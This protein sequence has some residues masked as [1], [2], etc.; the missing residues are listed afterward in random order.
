M[1][2]FEQINKALTGIKPLAALKGL[3]ITQDEATAFIDNYRNEKEEAAKDFASMKEQKASI[4]RMIKEASDHGDV[5]SA[6]QQVAALNASLA[7]V[8][9]RLKQAEDALNND[10]NIDLVSLASSQLAAAKLAEKEQDK[11][12]AKFKELRAFRLRVAALHLKAGNPDLASEFH[13]NRFSQED[14][15]NGNEILTEAN[16]LSL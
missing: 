13:I 8:N 6:G 4:E 7:I 11:L 12:K 3:N 1:E 2:R 15:V 16:R 5:I 10:V 14:L 9:N